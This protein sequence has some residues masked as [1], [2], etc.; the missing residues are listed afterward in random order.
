M[1]AK[2]IKIPKGRHGFLPAD[3]RHDFDLAVFDP[4]HPWELVRSHIAAHLH[5]AEACVTVKM[6]EHAV[7]DADLGTTVADFCNAKEIGADAFIAIAIAAAPVAAPVKYRR[8]VVSDHDHDDGRRY[9]DPLRDHRDA[10][11]TVNPQA[12]CRAVCGHTFAEVLAAGTGD[13]TCPFCGLITRPMHQKRQADLNDGKW[14]DAINGD[15][16]RPH[17]KVDSASVA[18][19]HKLQKCTGKRDRCPRIATTQ[20]GGSN[21]NRRVL[22]DDCFDGHI[23]NEELAL[24]K[25]DDGYDKDVE[26]PKKPVEL[27]VCDKH[28]RTPIN[29]YC[30]TQRCLVCPACAG[31]AAHRGCLGSHILEDAAVQYAAKAQAERAAAAFANIAECEAATHATEQTLA[32]NRDQ[33]NALIRQL[34]Q[35]RDAAKAAIDRQHEAM[36]RQVHQGKFRGN[37]ENGEERLLE[38]DAARARMSELATELMARDAIGPLSVV[39]LSKPLACHKYTVQSLRRAALKVE[40]AEPT[41]VWKL[42]DTSCEEVDDAQE[43]EFG[44][45]VKNYTPLPVE[46]ADE[47]GDEVGDSADVCVHDSATVS[48]LVERIVS[49]HHQPFDRCYALLVCHA[50]AIVEVL[51]ASPGHPND[52]TVCS[53]LRPTGR[54]LKLKVCPYTPPDASDIEC[55]VMFAEADGPSTWAPHGEPLL[56]RFSERTTTSAALA[57]LQTLTKIDNAS[58][59][60]QKLLTYTPTAGGGNIGYVRNFNALLTQTINPATQSLVI[61]CK[62]G[63]PGDPDSGE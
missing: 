3:K 10:T 31:E 44:V 53:R 32:A 35:Q 30:P 58:L 60:G 63:A 36:L 19:L 2:T 47:N 25:E 37:V 55:K 50:H 21:C 56:V 41:A 62:K 51:P 14:H 24:T 42:T 54:R 61:E 23:P 18:V 16:R 39:E 38:L 29:G 49:F 46:F 43:Q 57:H 5:V 8:I 22:C 7:T 9:V 11:T 15:H 1:A 12:L 6:G 13:I 28:T 59:G 20:C 48:E 45:M 26:H 34:D 17:A 27:Q 4:S 40:Y 33:W 52:T